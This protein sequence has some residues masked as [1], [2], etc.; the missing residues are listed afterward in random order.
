VAGTE[1]EKVE[2]PECGDTHFVTKDEKR[3]ICKCQVQRRIKYYLKG[4]SKTEEPG[5]WD[6]PAFSE[7]DTDQNL[8]ILW[9]QNNTAKI[10]GL[11]ARLLL[12]KGTGRNYKVLQ[13]YELVE[14]YLGL[15]PLTDSLF[16]LS[17]SPLIL[18]NGLME[19][20]NKRIE[21]ITLQVLENRKLNGQVTWFINK[22]KTNRLPNVDSY[23]NS[24][25]FHR[26]DIGE[27]ISR[28]DA[29]L[30]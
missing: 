6:L 25:N 18:V 29:R 17:W 10:Q 21:L 24:N 26:I 7:L 13:T 28:S 30:K 27:S 11:I 4:L 8:Y 5:V 23:L 16:K 14:I 1:E 15:H 2:C 9:N 19:M 12:T 3:V 22:G 20:E